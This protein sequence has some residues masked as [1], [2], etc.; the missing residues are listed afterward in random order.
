L[1]V[2]TTLFSKRM[3]KLLLATQN[4]G[5]IKEIESILSDLPFEIISLSKLGEENKQWQDLADVDVEETGS[6]LKENALLKAQ[7]FVDRT[8]LLTLAD[9]SGL[10]VEALDGFPGVKSNRWLDG[11]DHD[12]NLALLKKMEKIENRQASFVT[13]LCLIDPGNKTTKYFEGT[14]KGMIADQPRGDEG[15]GYDPIF[16]PAGFE[17]SFAQLGVKEKNKL[18]HRKQALLKLTQY[19]KTYNQNL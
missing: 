9:D 14:V 18:S 19:L 12:C 15:F 6:T 13:V 2:E 8:Q 11:S 7:Y 3:T 10:L 17:K 4:S 5:K 16:I 1:E